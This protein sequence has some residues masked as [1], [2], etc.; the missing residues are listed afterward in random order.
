VDN[1]RGYYCEPSQRTDNR[2]VGSKGNELKYFS[3]SLSR[4]GFVT[5]HLMSYEHFL[6]ANRVWS[7]L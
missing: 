1:L 3:P 7:K 6:N 5:S 4:G 2:L